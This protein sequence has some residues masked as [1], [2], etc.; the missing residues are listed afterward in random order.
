MTSCR[1]MVHMPVRFAADNVA[2]SRSSFRTQKSSALSSRRS[3]HR[4]G[5]R[6]P[7]RD[8]FA[9]HGGKPAGCRQLNR[10]SPPALPCAH[11]HAHHGTPHR[12]EAGSTAAA[13]DD[14][15]AAAAFA[16]KNLRLRPCRRQRTQ[17]CECE[18]NPKSALK[19]PA[20]AG[21]GRPDEISKISRPKSCTFRAQ[22][23]LI[24]R[25]KILP[26]PAAAGWTRSPSPSTSSP[27]TCPA[28][29]PSARRAP[30][31]PAPAPCG[32][33]DTA[34]LDSDSDSDSDLNLDADLNLNSDADSD[35]DSST[36]G[37]RR[38]VLP[39]GPA[40]MRDSDTVPRGTC[41][42]AG[43]PDLGPWPDGP[44]EGETLARRRTS[45][46]TRA[47]TGTRAWT[48]NDS[49]T[50]QRPG[51]QGPPPPCLPPRWPEL[52]PPGPRPPGWLRRERLLR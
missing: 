30:G 32:D 47:G 42:P 45:A 29:S 48:R 10:P 34:D 51:G 25:S 43:G 38:A 37:L 12:P 24:S 6:R 46:R 3:L 26:P 14:R 4:D 23:P 17:Q 7:L 33:S 22:N 21:S 20:L 16:L 1:Q 11:A 35:S 18:T 50:G 8:T 2:I 28:P 13:D 36:D 27:P 19:N 52:A 40:K 15:P 9:A 5:A 39:A 49:D 44:G 41:R 31:A